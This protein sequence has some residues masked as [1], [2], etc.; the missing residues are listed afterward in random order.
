V[1]D[2]GIG[3]PPEQ[4]SKIFDRFAQVD[5]SGTR[6]YE[7]TG[8]GLSLAAELV[9]MHGGRIWAESPGLGFGSTMCVELP[10]GEADDIDSEEAVVWDE[11]KATLEDRELINASEHGGERS[12][13]SDVLRGRANV[14]LEHVIDNWSRD[15]DLP[16]VME[17]R[18][19]SSVPEVLIADDNPDMRNLLVQLLSKEFRV[20]AAK[21]GREALEALEENEPSLVLTD[22]MMPEMSGTELCAAV[23]GNERTRNIPVV[24][25]T[26]KAEHGMKI[27][28]LELGADDYVTKPFHPRELMAR[29]RSLVRVRELQRK[30]AVKNSSL[31]EAL[32]RLRKAQVQLVQNERL[33]AV[34]ELAAGVAHEV[35]N[36]VNFSLNAART[37]RFEVESLRTS[38]ISL[39]KLGRDKSP[40]SSNDNVT[41]RTDISEQ[42][43][44]SSTAVILELCG[45]IT[46]GL[47]RTYQ[48]VGNLRDFA[49]PDRGIKAQ[50]DLKTG[51]ES[52][53]AL[54]RPTLESL[55]VA[56]QLNLPEAL[57][58]V[59]GDASAI[60]QIFMNLLK[61]AAEA[62][63]KE[64]GVI[65]IE[66]ESSPRDVTIRV[67]DSGPGIPESDLQSLFEPFFTTKFAGEGTGLGLS[68]S[69]QIA[70]SAGGSLTATNGRGSGAVFELRLPVNQ[71]ES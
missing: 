59:Y 47:E 39:G 18:H 37:L 6:R 48:L 36:P 7:G 71:W 21:N 26:S 29:V 3:I 57:P 41:V 13:G 17:C 58:C 53:T 30:L 9:E 15:G 19:P 44:Y 8:I 49:A 22:V 40:R 14:E 62:M 60:N 67:I 32:T 34:G 42:E 24:L 20:R 55:G 69:R 1:Q 63:R 31:E 28:G 51:L 35:N 12:Q 23:K 64:G 68:I 56:V 50:V 38:I 10:V 61:N 5:S 45:I 16:R 33:A 52:T 4:L 43:L 54:L 66:A 70:E 25:V 11:E 27:E 65:R 46:D 2:T